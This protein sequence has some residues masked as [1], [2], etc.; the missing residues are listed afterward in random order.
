MLCALK[1][2]RAVLNTKALPYNYIQIY[3]GLRYRK[4]DISNRCVY[5]GFPFALLACKNGRTV[6]LHTYDEQPSFCN[7]LKIPV[8]EIAPPPL[9]VRTLESTTFSVIFPQCVA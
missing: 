8:P 7:A 6:S 1:G 5:W 3:C 2:H 9:T 4:G